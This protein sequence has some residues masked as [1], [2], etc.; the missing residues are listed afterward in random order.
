MPEGSGG[1][2]GGGSAGGSNNV[3]SGS[4]NRGGGGGAS[5]GNIGAGGGSGRV[6]IQVP[7]ANYTGTTS[8]SPS[9]NTTGS[10]TVMV[11]NGSGS[12]T[13]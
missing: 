2:G 12:Y 6:V 7:T 11:F 3:Q 8:G 9:V 13:A 5:T 10:N 4:A 1:I